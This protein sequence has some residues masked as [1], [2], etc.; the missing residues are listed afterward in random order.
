MP[1]PSVDTVANTIGMPMSSS[2]LQRSSMRL[3][4]KM[5]PVMRRSPMSMSAWRNSSARSS[6]YSV[7]NAARLSRPNCSMASASSFRKGLRRP[8]MISAMLSPSA[9]LRPRALALPT[10]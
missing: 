7:T 10:K 9:C 8:R 3:P 2:A 6:M 4:T 5:M 1:V